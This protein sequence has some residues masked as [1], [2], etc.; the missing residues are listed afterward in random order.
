MKSIRRKDVSFKY[1]LE[2]GIS[3]NAFDGPE[4]DF[5]YDAVNDPLFRDFREWGDL[6]RYLISEDAVPEAI[7]AA[8][9]LFQRW[10]AGQ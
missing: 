8:A 9:V 10:K 7:D 3:R 4:L 2:Q 5:A 6:K 1:Y